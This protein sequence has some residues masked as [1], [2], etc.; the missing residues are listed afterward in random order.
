MRTNPQLMLSE[1]L[2]QAIQLNA[3][4]IYFSVDTP[5]TLRMDD[6][7]MPLNFE[8]LSAETIEDI[9][10]QILDAKNLEEFKT[11]WECNAALH[12]RNKAR[13]RINV[14]RQQLQPGVVLRRIQSKIPTCEELGL[15]DI[16][17]EVMML[18]RGLILVCG[19]VGT[20]KTSSIAAMVG[21]RNTHGAGHI[22][23][24]EDP[25]EFVHTPKQ[26]IITQ[27]DV[28]MDTISHEIALKN[29]LRQRPDVVMIG[30]I[31]DVSAMQQA[32]RFAE[33]GHLCIATLHSNN[34]YQTIERVVTFFEENQHKQV[35]QSLSL[36]LRAIFSQQLVE[37]SDHKRVP[38]LEI[39]LNE[40]LIK[41]L[42]AE[43]RIGEIREMMERNVD[44][45][46]RTFDYS[47][48]ELVR[49]KRIDEETALKYAENAAGMRLRIQ[50]AKYS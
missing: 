5:P 30:E 34:A 18:K 23:T 6:R 37:T 14:Y 7:L 36:N 1:V 9:L 16:Y 3:S 50:Q 38:L 4:D 39:M 32:L 21:H 45:G 22:I 12:W 26:C 44:R 31:R 46:M 47:I 33:T 49:D 28:G 25:I 48:L 41:S 13:F 29:A 11:T 20:G 35:L 42:I 43:G 8:P 27:R 19:A 17:K 40:G 10:P 24:V 15:P 2:D